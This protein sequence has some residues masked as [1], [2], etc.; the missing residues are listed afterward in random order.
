MRYVELPVKGKPVVR[1]GRKASGPR[2]VGSGV[3]GS[4]GMQGFEFARSLLLVF[5][6]APRPRFEAVLALC[7]DNYGTA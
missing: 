5:G 1:R 4:P 2:N 3:A 6:Q 7:V